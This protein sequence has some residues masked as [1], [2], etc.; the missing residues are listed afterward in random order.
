MSVARDWGAGTGRERRR[1]RRRR[2][3]EDHGIS[4]ARVRPGSD[5][6]VIDVSDGGA[7]LETSRRLLPGSSIDLQ[8]TSSAG[9]VAV[10]ARVIRC[11]VSQIEPGRIWYRGAVAFERHLHLFADDCP[12]RGGSSRPEARPGRHRLEEAASHIL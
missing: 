11:F 3:A 4:D 6:A 8:L 10:R 9:R 12:G 7:L 5:A 2:H 1:T